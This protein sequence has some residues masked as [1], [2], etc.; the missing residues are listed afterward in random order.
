VHGVGNYALEVRDRGGRLVHLLVVLDSNASR[1][2]DGG[3]EDYDFVY[4]DQIAWYEWLVKGASAERFGEW[5]PAAGKVL[6]STL[7]LH[8]P[9]PQFAEAAAAFDRGEID[10][11]TVRG[12]RHE[13]VFCPPVDSGLFAAVLRMGST[14]EILVG[15]DHVNDLSV[16][17]RGVRLSYVTKIGRTAYF[18]KG[19]QG[20]TLLTLRPRD[21][22]W[23][24]ESGRVGLE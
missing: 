6:P 16:P 8:I 14:A 19:M 18:R 4:P 24:A 17:W 3:V 7:L 23:V 10:P 9:P 12:E 15:H 1:I 5:D 13:D 2:Y 21:G 22:V 20:G 11:S